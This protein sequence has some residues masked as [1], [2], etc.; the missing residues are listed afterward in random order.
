MNWFSG[1]VVYVILWWLVFFMT[2]PFGIRAPHEVG[3][4]PGQGHADGAPVKPRLWLKAG[5]TSLIAAMLWGVAY[6]LIVS[7]LIS[8]RGG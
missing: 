6:V 2:L 3:E 7:D 8:F 5:V 1:V 4:E